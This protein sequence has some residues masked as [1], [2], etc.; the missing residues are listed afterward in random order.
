[1]AA[2]LCAAVSIVMLL[3]DASVPRTDIVTTYES[4]YAALRAVLKPGEPVGYLTDLPPNDTSNYTELRL[5]QYAVAPVIVV[6][7][8]SPRLIVG[9]F[10]TSRR[11]LEMMNSRN[12]TFVRDAGQ[13]V[14]LFRK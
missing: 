12:L 4:R 2:V 14:Y 13:G 9:N 6:N 7:N 10:R 5:M 8:E 3:R 11:M 1:M